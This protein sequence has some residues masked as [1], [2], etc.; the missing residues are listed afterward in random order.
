MADYKS[1]QCSKKEIF[2]YAVQGI[3]IFGV[4]GHL[5]FQEV[6]FTGIVSFGAV[7]Y[8]KRRERE[9]KQEKKERLCREFSQGAEA[10]LNALEAGYSKENAVCEAIKDLEGMYEG[11]SLI[12][13]EFLFIQRQIKVNRPMEALFLELGKKSGIEDIEAFGEVF[14]IAGKS[15]GNLVHIIKK[16]VGIIREKQ[17][18]LQEIRVQTAA[19]RLEF[20]IMCFIVPGIIAY[21]RLFSPGFLDILYH[22]LLGRFFM[23]LVL[24]AYLGAVY[25]GER[26]TEV[27]V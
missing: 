21:L 4:L 22:N 10:L 17:A 3:V 23:G 11:D 5:F 15:G 2:L 19:K 26:M 7:F 12:L 18:L 9:R 13:P 20:R 27:E 25:L 1:L 16:T 24:S 14:S 6:L 8:V